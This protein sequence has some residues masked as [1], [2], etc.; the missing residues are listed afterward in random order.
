MIWADGRP[1]LRKFKQFQDAEY[2]VEGLNYS[3]ADIVIDGVNQ[4]RFMCKSLIIK[5]K[6]HPVHVGSGL[7]L[8]DRIAFCDDPSLIVG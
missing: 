5:H 2:I 1:D 8:A 6:G 7:S 4:T 3:N